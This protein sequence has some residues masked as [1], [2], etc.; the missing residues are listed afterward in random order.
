M[1][2][3]LG[4]GPKDGPR[5]GI[6]ADSGTGPGTDPGSGPRADPETGP[7]PDSAAGVGAGLG[8]LLCSEF[9][10]G[11]G[12][13]ERPLSAFSILPFWRIGDSESLLLLSVLLLLF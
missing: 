9:A 11:L 2:A 7:G 1:V 6:G 12:C 10:F 5:A 13:L 4:T 3:G 8:V